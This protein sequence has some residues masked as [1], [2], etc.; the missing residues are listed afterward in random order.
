L[1][2]GQPYLQI[3]K[4][5]G[6]IVEAI[7]INSVP[8][9]VVFGNK[10]SPL[11]KYG[12]GGVSGKIAQP[13]T[14][15]MVLELARGTSIPVIGASIWEYEDILRL[16][17]LGASAYHLGAIFLPYPWRPSAYVKCWMREQK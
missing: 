6:G 14:W 10:P 13:F 4:R 11:A 9:K 15:K 3:A 8:W 17:S 16:K 5:V 1:S 2:Y 12:G 7:S